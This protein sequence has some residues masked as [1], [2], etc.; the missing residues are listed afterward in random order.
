MTERK[1]SCFPGVFSPIKELPP[2]SRWTQSPLAIFHLI[3]TRLFLASSVTACL[4]VA[5]GKQDP[6]ASAAAPAPATVTPPAPASPTK[7]LEIASPVEQTPEETKKA[8]APAEAPLAN[9]GDFGS[10]DPVERTDLPTR[11]VISLAPKDG[12][13]T[14]MD[15]WLQFDWKYKAKRPGHYQVRMQ[16]S[17]DHASLGVQFKL[18]ETRLRKTLTSSPA[19]RRTYLGEIFIADATEQVLSVYAPTSAHSARFDL[20]GIDLVPTNEGEPTVSQATDGSVVL[21]AKDATTWSETMRYESKPEKNCLGYWTDPNDFAEWEF[22]LQQPG[23]YQVI[24]THGCGGGNAGSEVAVKVGTQEKKFTVQ[25]TGGFQKW[26]DVLVGE[27][28][29]KSSGVQRLVVDPLNKVKSAV[30]DVQKVVLK[31]VS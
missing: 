6:A 28:E 5:C 24:V 19:P 10:D 20:L 26:Q 18:G 9:V 25:E 1:S 30:L 4:L 31:P 11:G 16:Y 21:L 3:M 22:Q 17:L 23:R 13:M 27:I 2:A 12:V 14:N 29:I 15:H 7:P 8:P